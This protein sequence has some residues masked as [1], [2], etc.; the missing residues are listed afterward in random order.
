MKRLFISLLLLL[1]PLA[2]IQ[3]QEKESSNFYELS[4][5]SEDLFNRLKTYYEKHCPKYNGGT[6]DRPKIERRDTSLAWLQV[7][8]DMCEC[9]KNAPK[10]VDELGV[11]P[12]NEMRYSG[13]WV[14]F[15]GSNGD[16][17]CDKTIGISFLGSAIKQTVES[18]RLGKGCDIESIASLL[19]QQGVNPDKKPVPLFT[20]IKDP[21][22]YGGS[23]T[24]FEVAL[25]H[26]NG[27]RTRVA[28]G[29]SPRAYNC[30]Q[31]IV[32]LL[33]RKQKELRDLQSHYDD[34][35]TNE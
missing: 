19:N 24:A 29:K 28:N 25:Y 16:S 33:M 7:L 3:G 23:F 12:D 1:T 27:E 26:A 10:I 31:K 14:R 30:A 13:F 34:N 2:L 17:D 6:G 15:S 35:E 5:E 21:D 11:H 32:Q 9:P 18:C 22:K 4:K 8:G 20:W